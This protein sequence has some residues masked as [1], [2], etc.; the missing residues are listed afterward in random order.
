[1]VTHGF[2][3]LHYYRDLCSQYIIIDIMAK[4]MSERLNYIC[5]INRQRMRADE[6]IRFR[7]TL[8]QDAKYVDPSAN[9]GQR[10]ILPFSFTGFLVHCPRCP[11]RLPGWL[12]CIYCCE[13]HP[14]RFE[15]SQFF[16]WWLSF[17]IN[18]H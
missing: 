3:L 18:T 15:Q 8:N 12:N 9:I 2:Y 17:L 5:L 16:K 4:M 6:Y 10:I 11:P 13:S 7:D 14:K 1:M